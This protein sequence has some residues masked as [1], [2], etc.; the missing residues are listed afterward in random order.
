MLKR[1][2]V[3]ACHLEV[4][5]KVDPRNSEEASV[6]RCMHLRLFAARTCA[7]CGHYS[8]RIHKQKIHPVPRLQPAADAAAFSC[9]QSVGAGLRQKL[10]LWSCVLTLPPRCLMGRLYLS[11][12]SQTHMRR[13]S[14]NLGAET[15]SA[16]REPW[17]YRLRCGPASLQA[18]LQLH[19]SA[20]YAK[21][22]LTKDH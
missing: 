16:S 1:K 5:F 14:S 15:F 17:S 9:A 2:K 3:C 13:L 11:R 19:P 7:R 18:A 4:G 8:R 12:Q 21:T 20:S 6:R 10:S 22:K